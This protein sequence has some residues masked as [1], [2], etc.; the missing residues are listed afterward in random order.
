M[1]SILVALYLSKSFRG[2]AYASQIEVDETLTQLCESS[3]DIFIS[4]YLK[5][6]NDTERIYI[7]N[8]RESI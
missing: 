7:T 3:R 5:K 1:V 8:D 2:H 6:M 4:F